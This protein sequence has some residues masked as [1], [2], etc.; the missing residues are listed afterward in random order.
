MAKGKPHFVAKTGMREAIPSF[1][2]WSY[3]ES[4]LLDL[5][6][7]LHSMTEIQRQLLKDCWMVQ[8]QP[9]LN[10]VEYAEMDR[11]YCTSPQVH[12]EI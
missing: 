2:G 10:G 12:S 1:L 3:K 8:C 5:V 7:D 4:P 9:Y 6:A 11:C